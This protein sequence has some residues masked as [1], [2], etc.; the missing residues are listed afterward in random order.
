MSRISWA[1]LFACVVLCMQSAMAQRV[2]FERCRFGD[3]VCNTK[4]TNELLQ[5]YAETGVRILHIPPFDPLHI[6]SLILPPNPNGLI[7]VR[8]SFTDVDIHGLKN[9]QN[10][11]IDGFTRD[12]TSPLSLSCTVPKARFSGAYEGEGKILGVNFK[13]KGNCVIELSDI[14]LTCKID[15]KLVQKGGKNYLVIK[16]VS[17]VM[18]KP[19]NVHYQLDGLYNGNPELSATANDFL[20]ANADEI[21]EG[22]RLNLQETFALIVHNYMEKV[23]NEWAYDDLFLPE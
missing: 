21:F 10:I 9:A 2:G 13:G 16:N 17:L 5:K 19:K 7:N 3:S 22:M 14:N 15:A 20:N 8:L 11:K 4:I 12:V 18:S 6:K 1:P 23:F